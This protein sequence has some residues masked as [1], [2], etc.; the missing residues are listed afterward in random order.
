MLEGGAHALFHKMRPNLMLINVDHPASDACVRSLA[1]RH[2]FD[3]HTL[4]VPPPGVRLKVGYPRGKHVVLANRHAAE[5]SST[6][7]LM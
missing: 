3:V 4:F 5:R 2:N 1:A 7:E 6:H